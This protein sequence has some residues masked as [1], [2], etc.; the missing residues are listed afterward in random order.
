MK[1]KYVISIDQGTTSSL[2]LVLNEKIEVVDTFVHHFEQIINGEEVFQDA[3]LIYKG[4]KDILDQAIEKYKKEN[5]CAIGIT[6]QRET[7]VVFDKKGN[8]IMNAI[9]WQSKHTKEI[10]E[11]WKILGYETY[12]KRVTGLPINP[13][14]SASKMSWFLTQDIVKEYKNRNDALFG[15]MDAYL[16]YR[17]TDGK[18]Y[19][20]DVTNASRTMLFDINKMHYDEKLLTDFKIPINMLPKVKP[21]TYEFG[22]YQGIPIKAMIGDQQSALFGHLAFECGTM[23]TT[24]GT[25]AFILMNTGDKVFKSKKGLIST[26][27]FQ[28]DEKPVYALEGSIFVAGSSVNWL[29]DNLSLI[30]TSS[31]SEEFALSSNKEIYF[32]PAFVGLGAPY[33]DSDVRGAM[34]GITADVNKYDIVKATLD[35]IAY[36][37]KDVVDVMVKESTIP[38]KKVFIDGGVTNNNYLMQFQSDLLRCPLI[39]PKNTEV[40]A[41]GAAFLAGLGSIYP[42]IQYIIDNKKTLKEF[43]PLMKQ[44]IAVKKYKGWQKAVKSARSYKLKSRL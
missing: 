42:N 40:T 22:Y 17:L 24:Y 20:T 8:P 35:A 31:E 21:N 41:L 28:I 19:F 36:Q 37:V 32:V 10:C 13:Y 1:H 7:T 43:K 18:S 29:K 12:V 4:V 26:V 6:N 38:L 5:I 30:H 14:F 27:A 3:D 9:G 11:N 34:F 16:L 2:V 44:S 23:K 33:W 39:K 15:T 25:G